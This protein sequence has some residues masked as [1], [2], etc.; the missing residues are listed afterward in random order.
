MTNTG[1][2]VSQILDLK[3]IRESLS[4]G[5]ADSVEERRNNSCGL[6]SPDGLEEISKAA[7]EGISKAVLGEIF[8]AVSDVNYRVVSVEM[9]Y[10]DDLAER[11][12]KV[13]LDGK[14]CRAVLAEKRKTRVVSDVTSSKAVLDEKTKVASDG[15]MTKAVLVAIRSRADLDA[16]NLTK[17]D[18]DVKNLTKG[19]LD[20]TKLLRMKIKD[21]LVAKRTAMISL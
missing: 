2:V 6:Q 12:S 16:K 9:K 19:D 8:K 20:V 5:R 14:T 15:K 4:I 11:I 17:G 1:K 13:A 10:R 18:L 7:L 3:W 21:D